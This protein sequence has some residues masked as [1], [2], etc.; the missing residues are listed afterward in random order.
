M[1]GAETK[2][3]LPQ[4][5]IYATFVGQHPSSSQTAGYIAKAT[6]TPKPRTLLQLPLTER[7]EKS[8]SV[9]TM[10]AIEA[11]SKKGFRKAGMT[12]T[13]VL[14]CSVRTT[15]TMEERKQENKACTLTYANYTNYLVGWAGSSDGKGARGMGRSR[16]EDENGISGSRYPLSLDQR[17]A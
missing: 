9:C 7:M 15:E 8:Y 16:V 3:I 12:Q 2:R 4:Y 10:Y 1:R 11:S 6:D 14:C 17:D 5:R 13:A